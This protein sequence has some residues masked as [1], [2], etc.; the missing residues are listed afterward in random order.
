MNIT[1]DDVLGAIVGMHYP[2]ADSALDSQALEGTERLAE[3]AHWVIR[4]VSL[5]GRVDEYFE[6]RYPY[7]SGRMVASNHRAV[8]MDMLDWY[9]Q[10]YVMEYAE[11][12]LGMKGGDAE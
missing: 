4:E 7:A 1:L 9:P 11:K 5:S 10:E 3:I 12:Y 2:Q 6:D 8:L